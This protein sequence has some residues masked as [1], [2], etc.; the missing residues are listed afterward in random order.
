M[1]EDS[2]RTLVTKGLAVAS[3]QRTVS[4]FLLHQGIFYQKRHDCR[5]PPTLLFCVFS[6]EDETVRPS[7]W[8]NWGDRGRIA[9]G[10]EHPHR[11]R[12]PGCIKND[13]IIGNSA[14]AL[15][16]TIW[17]MMWPVGP[18]WVFDLTA[19]SVPETMDTNLNLLIKCRWVI[20]FTAG[21][22]P[23]P[24]RTHWLGGWV[25]PIVGLDAMEK[26]ELVPLRELNRGRPWLFRLSYRQG[27]GMCFYTV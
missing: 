21:E 20:I 10:A 7:F 24:P 9:G 18:K 25:Y 6:I 2:P 8:H 16:G 1:C 12:L 15:L 27:Y 4:H 13:R 26:R 23:P 19:G 17:R 14:Y 11:T 5:P 3:W 22:S